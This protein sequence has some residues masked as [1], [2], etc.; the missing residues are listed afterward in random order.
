MKLSE[1]LK[2]NDDQFDKQL[3]MFDA[4][5]KSRVLSKSEEHELRKSLIEYEHT[6]NKCVDGKII[7]SE[8]RP[9]VDEFEAANYSLD[10][11]KPHVRNSLQNT[12][13]E[14]K[15]CIENDPK[16]FKHS[17]AKLYCDLYEMFKLNKASEAI[18][19]LKKTKFFKS[20]KLSKE[21]FSIESLENYLAEN[22]QLRSTE[23]FIDNFFTKLLHKSQIPAASD[24]IQYGM[25]LVSIVLV[26]ITISIIALCIINAQYRAELVK[27]LDKLSDDDVK[28]KG[29]LKTRQDNV[30][31][32]ALAMEQNMPNLTKQT[33]VKASKYSIRQI[34]QLSKADYSAL[35]K[36]VEE[37]NQECNDI[38]AQSEEGAIEDKIIQIAQPL[39]DK[40]ITFAAK[41]KTAIIAVGMII[42]AVKVGIPLLRACIYQFKSWRIRMSTFFEEQVETTNANIE[43]LIELRDKPTTSQMEKDRLNKIIQKQR[44]WIK[45]MTAWANMFYKSEVDASSDTMYEI[46]QDEKIDFDKLAY[47][48][49]S[50]EESSND[51]LSGTAT[52]DDTTID[53]ET[54]PVPT[55]KPVV[56]F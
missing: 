54:E 26:L 23:G 19:R 56:L 39:Y 24:S 47:D 14:L 40:F 22:G 7:S 3:D 32:A 10:G 53:I 50:A 15:Y 41:Y 55:N 51:E 35:D 1:I 5:P 43:Y 9:I 21:S 42:A 13:E 2:L 25:F 38:V 11:L 29:A 33:I 12:Y 4:I 31:E 17:S 49:E 37:F 16:T 36:S 18:N 30:K 52:T 6:L 8:L 44:V 46:R 20:S 48:Q 28:L 34:N 45:N 27:I